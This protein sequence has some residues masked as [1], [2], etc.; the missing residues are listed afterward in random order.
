MRESALS[1][2]REKLKEAQHEVQ[3]HKARLEEKSGLLK[4]LTTRGRQ[5]RDLTTAQSNLQHYDSQLKK[6]E[7]LVALIQKDISRWVEC[8]LKTVAPD[9]VAAFATHDHPED[10]ARFSYS[11]EL[12][13]KSFR[14]GLQDLLTVFGRENINGPRS[15]LLMDS[16]RKLLPLA[17]QIEIDAEFFNRILAQREKQMLIAAGRATQHP[18]YNW[19]EAVDQLGVLP[20]DPALETLNELLSGC[21]GFLANLHQAI[22]REQFLVETRAAQIGRTEGRKQA[23]LQSWLEGLRAASRQHVNVDKLAEI[24]TET[25][26]LLMDGE[27]TARFNR[28][29]VQ[30]IPPVQAQV[31]APAKRATPRTT[32]AVTQSDDELRALK[33]RLQAEWDEVAKITTELAVRERT[34]TENEQK[35]RDREQAFAENGQRE[36]TALDEAKA[37]LAALEAGIVLKDREAEAKRAEQAARLEEMQAEADARAMFLEESEQRLLNK[38]QEQLE[39]LAEIEQKE[40]ELMA[41]KRELNAMRKE[42]GI[43]MVAL[44]S[45]PVDE[46]SE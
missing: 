18:E 25:E 32:P 35:L 8:S 26:S 9:Y 6:A 39:I 1:L 37:R 21:T 27:F 12:V 10:W 40:E 3:L 29:L 31:V 15:P 14:M 43:P 36:Q 42:I 30:S 13:M 16:V 4:N 5:E 33:A 22:K 44:R 2:A 20:L 11:F 17:R 45:Q 28:Y 23:Y 38:G 41:T 24:V 7:S 19:C 34:V 46:F